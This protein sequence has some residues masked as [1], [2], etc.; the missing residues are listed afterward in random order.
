MTRIV[1][2]I[3]PQ[4]Y[5]AATLFVQCR[6]ARMAKPKPEK[7]PASYGAG[8]ESL[9]FRPHELG[10]KS[11]SANPETKL[12]AFR[13]Q[14][15]GDVL[16]QGCFEMRGEFAALKFER[17]TGHGRQIILSDERRAIFEAE[18]RGDRRFCHVRDGAPFVIPDLETS[19]VQL[20]GPPAEVQRDRFHQQ[21]VLRESR[22]AGIARF[23]VASTTPDPCDAVMRQAPILNLAS[24]EETEGFLVHRGL[25][26]S[27]GREHTPNSPGS[28]PPTAS[29][30][31]ARVQA[32]G[33]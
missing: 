26:G 10:P 29:T 20:N 8:T 24:D 13:Q 6:R 33:Q 28:R 1:N 23:A 3:A 7:K 22:V 32:R 15:L 17:F 9:L 14:F 30:R 25:A 11:H 27:G 2:G 12:G 21:L 18:A 16:R 4:E 19:D 5:G 31:E